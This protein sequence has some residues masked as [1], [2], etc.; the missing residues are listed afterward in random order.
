[1]S[2]LPREPRAIP[3]RFQYK[4]CVYQEA[5]YVPPLRKAPGT[6]A[7]SVACCG[8]HGSTHPAHP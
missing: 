2:V 1:M 6:S 3:D 5:P 4:L 7:A 8:T